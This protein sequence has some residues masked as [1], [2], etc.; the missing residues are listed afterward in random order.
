MVQGILLGCIILWAGAGVVIKDTGYLSMSRLLG[1]VVL[2]G[3][4]GLPGA[5]G[6]REDVRGCLLTSDEIAEELGN[7]RV[8][9]GWRGGESGKE[10]GSR[11]SAA[12]M[13]SEERRRRREDPV[14]GE[15]GVFQMEEQ[16][17][18]GAEGQI[19]RHIDLLEEREGLG[20]DTTFPP[21]RYDGLR[22]GDGDRQIGRGGGMR[23]RRG[24]RRKS[25]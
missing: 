3:L 24:Q 21:G 16:G 5:G 23:R 7:V 25:L 17:D 1:P 18:I 22:Y 19:V 9:Y 13:V 2:G 11:D 20:S 6:R 12:G 10:M 4:G 8:R 14:D 15:D